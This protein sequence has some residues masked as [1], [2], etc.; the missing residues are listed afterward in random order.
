MSQQVISDDRS[1]AL[2]RDV[3]RH[4]AR[5]VGL[6]RMSNGGNLPLGVA[7]CRRGMSESDPLDLTRSGMVGRS[8]QPAP[9]KP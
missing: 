5:T 7:G 2:A 8:S 6:T 1:F 4:L 9:K 3:R